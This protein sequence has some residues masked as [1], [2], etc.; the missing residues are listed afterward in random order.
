MPYWCSTCRS[1]FSVKTGTP[2]A[3]SRVPL[4][5]WAFAVYLCSTST[6]GISSLKLHRD[7]GVTQRTAWYM[8]H[9]I[10][11]GLTQQNAAGTT[12]SEGA[13]TASPKLNGPL[14]VEESYVGGKE[15]LKHWNKRIRAWGGVVGKA[16]VIG[17]RD[18]DTQKVRAK[19]IENITQV[20][21]E[22]FI[23]TTTK[24]GTIIYTDQS[25]PYW[26]IPNRRAVN[27]GRGIYVSGN[28]STNGIG[29]IWALL[30]RACYGCYHWISKKHL[31]RYVDE[32]VGRHNLRCQNMGTLDMM[33]MIV[34]GWI[35][36]EM[37]YR[38]LVA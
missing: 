21:A 29:S 32:V 23:G 30:K 14:E 33:R 8:L 10:R 15:R 17:I 9:R 19:H 16:P 12:G 4:Q 24:L 36:Q 22:E 7:I 35:G 20:Q 26:N 3:H 6:K 31:H 27:H 18:R 11:K 25:R 37:T 2:L 1:Y 5:K 13:S 28:A 34:T 38:E